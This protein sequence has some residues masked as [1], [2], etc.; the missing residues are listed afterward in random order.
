MKLPNGLKYLISL[1]GFL[2]LTACG[3]DPTQSP[4]SATASLVNLPAG[5]GWPCQGYIHSLD[6]QHR[7]CMR[8]EAAGSSH[9]SVDVLVEFR[10]FTVPQT[11][12]VRAAFGAF[13]NHWN[14]M[15]LETASPFESSFGKCLNT[16]AFTEI[17]AQH[18]SYPEQY[19]NKATAISWGILNIQ[20]MFE[21][22]ARSKTPLVVT[23]VDE[24]G[25]MG[26]S[27]LGEEAN[28]NENGDLNLSSHALDNPRYTGLTFA[29]TLLHEW[30]HRRGY[31]H[32]K[33]GYT[34][35][36]F[37]GTMTVAAGLCVRNNNILNGLALT[38][39]DFPYE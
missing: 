18:S 4:S 36:V 5:L 34:D 32:P 24:P 29:G 8:L 19:R 21:Y 37:R 7:E 38:G 27:R 10:G 39:F 22:H 23:N 15:R 26:S 35:P 31:M 25:I 3:R 17:F 20:Y 14:T 9:P 13:V 12:K 16:N 28:T 6:A 33:T 30:F 11:T 1:S 2:V